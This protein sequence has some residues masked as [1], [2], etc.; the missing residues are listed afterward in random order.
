MTEPINGFFVTSQEAERP[1]HIP[2]ERERGVSPERSSKLAGDTII[3][4]LKVQ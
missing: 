2:P 1:D 3:F 4:F